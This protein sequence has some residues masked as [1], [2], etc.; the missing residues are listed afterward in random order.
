VVVGVA[1]QR[2]RLDGDAARDEGDVAW[3]GGHW[4]L[5]GGGRG[6]GAQAVFI[7]VKAE[8]QVSRLFA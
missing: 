1:A 5:T 8:T 4:G 7:S 6:G 3:L 2:L